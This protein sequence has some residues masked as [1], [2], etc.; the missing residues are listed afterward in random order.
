M[1]WKFARF[2]SLTCTFPGFTDEEVYDVLT[3]EVIRRKRI[4]KG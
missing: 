1:T 2:V 3:R 4:L